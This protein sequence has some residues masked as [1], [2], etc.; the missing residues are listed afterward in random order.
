[1]NV[2]AAMA[3]FGFEMA[4]AFRTPV[5]TFVA[6]TVSTLLF[7]IVFG[8][9]ASTSGWGQAHYGAFVL[10]GALMLLVF[11]QS[12]S[13]AA[14]GIFFPKFLGTIFE[15]LAAPIGGV[16]ILAGYVGAAVTK[17]LL[18]AAFALTLAAIVMPVT[19]LHLAAMLWLLVL[20]SVAF[21]L[22]GFL[23][24]VWA[25]RVER[26]QTVPMVVLTPLTFL[27]GAFYDVTSL[28]GIW[29]IISQF[30][31]VTHIVAAFRWSFEGG[32]A[33]EFWSGMSILMLMIAILSGFAIWVLRT[34]YRLRH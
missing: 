30:N 26:L 21:S 7:V 10:P 16:E 17:S 19:V 9:A 33:S 29:P 25:A 34:G 6:P 1:M 11:T 15:I 28:P 4:R 24:G 31:P 5:Q 12:V 27:G 20:T 32:G 13:N 22:L 2:R 8:T 18:L 14:F 23:V 3:I